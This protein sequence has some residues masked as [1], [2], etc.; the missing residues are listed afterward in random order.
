MAGLLRL[1]GILLL[2]G[3]TIS[4]LTLV[5][6]ELVGH[7]LPVLALGGSIE[8]FSL[9]VFGGGWIRYSRAVPF[10]PA[11]QLTIQL[12][13]IAL[14]LA[15]GALALLW[16]RWRRPQ[17]LAHI[18]ALTTAT[19]LLIHAGFYLAAGTW[20]GFGDGRGLYHRLGPSRG[21]VAFPVGLTLV[22]LA[23]G[24]ARHLMPWLRRWTGAAGRRQLAV[25]MAAIALAAAAHAG[26]TLAE[27]ALR[28]DRIYEK[29]MRSAPT[30]DEPKPFPLKEVL[31]VSVLVAFGAGGASTRAPSEQTALPGRR[32]IRGLLAV[33]G[34]SIGLCWGL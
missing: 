16:I 3:L 2:L 14:E 4:R 26:L 10:G 11:E 32:A 24:L 5:L 12:G 21:W 6:H 18:A 27:R 8:D 9:F 25:A 20:H 28:A 1:A 22:A 29:V 34:L 19:C 15:I 31:A 33:T 23:A 30:R 13:G 7:G 17:P